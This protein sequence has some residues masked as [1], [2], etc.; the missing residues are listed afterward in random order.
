MVVKSAAYSELSWIVETYTKF[1][2]IETFPYVNLSIAAVF[3]VL[4]WFGGTMFPG[5]SLVPRVF[6]LW[7]FALV[8]YIIMS[9]TMSACIELLGYSHGFLVVLN[10]S[11][12][13]AMFVLLNAIVFKSKLTWRHYVAFILL[14]AA[15]ALV[16]WK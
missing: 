13:L 2:P 6:V 5:F 10:H 12:A 7:M 15:V 3:Q 14:T 11:L 1:L 4:A 8:E 16:Q 9:P